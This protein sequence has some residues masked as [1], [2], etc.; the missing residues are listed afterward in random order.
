M[1][2]HVTHYPILETK[3]YIPRP[4]PDLVQRKHLIDR[5]NAGVYGK[6]T[7]IAA[8][9]GFGKTTVLSK[10]VSQSKLPVAWISVDQGDNDPIYFIN[11]IIAALQKIETE[12]GEEVLSSLKTPQ[13]PPIDSIIIHLIQEIE[14]IPEDFVLVLDDYHFIDSEKVHQLIELLID[15]MPRQMHLAIATRVD[16][17]L[18]VARLRV[19]QQFTEF[20]ASDLCF[21]LDDAALFFN[22]VMNLGLSNEEIALL[23]SRTEGWVAGLQLA[24]LSMRSR[25]DIP[26]FI[27]A[28]A[29]D[30]RLV[31]DYLTEE[32]LN[33]QPVNVKNFLLRTSIL[34]RLSEPL[35]GDIT[36]QKGSQKTLEDLERANLFIVPMD[37]KRRWYRYHHLF[38]DLLRQKLHQKEPDMVSRLH[39]KASEWFETNGF[40]EEAI[41]HALAAKEFERAANV[42]EALI[43]ARWRGGEQVTLF[44]WLDQLPDDLKMGKPNLGLY[45]A[46]VL[47]QSGRQESAEKC[48]D[49]LE[50]IYIHTPK[51]IQRMSTKKSETADDNAITAFQGRIAAI[52]AYMATRRGDIPGIAK[53]SQEAL[54]CL[55]EEDA[56]WR[57]I[58]IIS[59]AIIHELKGDA[60]ASIDAHS[61]AIAA[62][63]KAGNV[64]FY[65]IE[66]LW[67]AIVMKNSGRLPEAMEICRQLLN[68]VKEKTLAFNAAVGNAWGTWGEMLYELNDL[69]AA[70]RYASKGVLLLEQ[71]HDVSHLGWRYA[72]LAEILCSKNNLRDA[73]E[74]ILKMDH[75]MATS[76][77][78]PWVLTRIEAV[79]A[80]VYLR[81]GNFN[82]LK[83]WVDE[84]GLKPDDTLTALH[85]PEHIMLARILIAQGR[86]DD[87]LGLLSR[88]T[89]EEAKAGRVLHQIETLVLQAIAFG[90]KNKAAE[91]MAAA[92]K[93]LSLA[94]PGGY[95]RVFVDEGP[96]LAE[97]LE[98]L[99]D[100]TRDIPRTFVKHILPAFKLRKLI[101][102]NDGLV[103]QLSDRELEVLKFIAAGLPNKKIAEELFISMNTVK[104]HLQNI[105]G[106]LNVHSRA[107]AVIK[108]TELNLLR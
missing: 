102:T 91:S 107:K 75:L 32:V 97:V 64:Y 3:L 29:G 77:V 45:H 33:R 100:T 94:E 66:R 39:I 63:M 62:T 25:N 70:Y 26:E 67:L 50:K 57:A 79:E 80:R 24:A 43:L 108:A 13:R 58:V 30:D 38:A 106:K 9:A 81:K 53:Y 69:D 23:E 73:E 82:S 4:G 12:F 22:E 36:G 78:P 84:C 55:S 98:K 83:K 71:G 44:N 18:K 65:L 96:P 92:A 49:Q 76:V 85:E 89:A 95:I 8:P 101:E 6:L 52:R 87:A 61:E 28:F 21:T 16:P 48:I 31:V 2:T 72:G 34:N 93:A 17:D 56:T 5:L 47:F 74:I 103:E 68:D 86:F 99:L 51:R 14:N 60:K 88:L 37:N 41:E 46:Q 54:A 42:I 1:Q 35:C 90:K 27:K 10:W 11:Y 7:L 20:R 105:Y 59:S 19:T 40:K 104:T 15:R